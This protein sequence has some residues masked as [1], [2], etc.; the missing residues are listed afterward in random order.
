MLI[1]DATGVHEDAQRTVT[2]LADA[3]RLEP[4]EI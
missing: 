2:E 1:V 4:G 3:L